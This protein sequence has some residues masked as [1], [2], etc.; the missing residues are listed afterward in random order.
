[1]GDQ[2]KEKTELTGR[3]KTKQTPRHMKRN[4]IQESRDGKYEGMGGECVL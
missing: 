3:K 4:L 2:D 1:M